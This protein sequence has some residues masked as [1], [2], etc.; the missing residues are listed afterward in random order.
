MGDGKCNVLE[1]SGTDGQ[2]EKHFTMKLCTYE[3]DPCEERV[4][5]LVNN[6]DT[7]LHSHRARLLLT[8]VS[9]IY[10]LHYSSFLQFGLGF[11]Y[12]WCPFTSIQRFDCPSFDTHTGITLYLVIKYLSSALRFI[13]ATRLRVRRSGLDSRQGRIFLFATTYRPAVGATQPSIL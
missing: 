4:Y 8:E 3:K 9:N 2:Y 6:K 13:M 10:I 7:I 11:L 12:N 1:Y 5:L